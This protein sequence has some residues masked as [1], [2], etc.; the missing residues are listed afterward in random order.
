MTAY[1]IY[2]VPASWNK[3]PSYYENNDVH[4]INTINRDY[5]IM[6]GDV[7]RDMLDQYIVIGRVVSLGLITNIKLFVKSF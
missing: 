6:A 4:Y 5:P 1:E 3:I 2:E 7:L